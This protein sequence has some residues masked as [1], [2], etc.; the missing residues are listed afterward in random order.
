MISSDLLRCLSTSL[1]ELEGWGDHQVGRARCSLVGLLI[2]ENVHRNSMRAFP[3]LDGVQSCVPPSTIDH[4]GSLPL[5]PEASQIRDRKRSTTPRAE[6]PSWMPRHSTS[7]PG[8]L[9]PPWQLLHS[10]IAHK[11]GRVGF[12]VL[13]PFSILLFMSPSSCLGCHKCSGFRWKSPNQ[14]LMVM[15]RELRGNGNPY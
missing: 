11:K 10:S 13:T 3:V 5:E 4:R 14:S 9:H 1:R 8:L 15:L 7:H 2:C 12:G 6:D